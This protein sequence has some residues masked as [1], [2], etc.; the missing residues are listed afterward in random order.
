MPQRL[1]HDIRSSRELAARQSPSDLIANFS[2]QELQADKCPRFRQS[3]LLL[4]GQL[5]HELLDPSTHSVIHD[6]LPEKKA[7][8]PRK[9]Y[10]IYTQRT[11]YKFHANDKV[12]IA[13]HCAPGTYSVLT[14][15]PYTWRPL[16]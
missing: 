3:L 11:F 7:V 4:R 8:A 14:G 2:R 9:K 5:L 12:G 16:G 15:R 13:P 6:L 1:R 10:R